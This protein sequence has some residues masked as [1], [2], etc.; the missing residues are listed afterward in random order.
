MTMQKVPAPTAIPGADKRRS[1]RLL[2]SV[3]VI[4]RGRNLKNVAFEEE[5]HTLVVN[6]HGGLVVLRA[7]VEKGQRI[8]LKHKTTEEEIECTVVFLGPTH[9]GK[10]QVGFEFSR[11]AGH[12]WHISFPPPDWQ[13][14][15]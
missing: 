7:S 4:V 11:P 5:T 9:A 3:P 6:A 12:F 14:V 13:P 8:M 10:A 2:L 1:Q 15:I